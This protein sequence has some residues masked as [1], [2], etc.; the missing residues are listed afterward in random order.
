MNNS[1]CW[2]ASS[3]LTKY[4]RNVH[5]FKKKKMI[6]FS[7]PCLPIVPWTAAFTL[8]ADL[9]P[10]PVPSGAAPAAWLPPSPPV[11]V[12]RLQP[13]MPK[14]RRRQLELSGERLMKRVEPLKTRSISRSAPPKMVAGG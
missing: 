6:S 10:F 5:L 12:H 9:G 13:S 11:P 4:V 3:W 2:K 14:L 1:R 8:K 7:N